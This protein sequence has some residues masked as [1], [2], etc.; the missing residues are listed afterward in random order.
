LH[1]ARWPVLL[2][3]LSLTSCTA[4]SPL[5]DV[6]LAADLFGR[7]QPH[8]RLAS[9]DGRG[10]E[11]AV[12]DL[13][14]VDA[15]P[16]TPCP[17]D[18]VLVTTTCLDRYEAP[19]L[20]GQL[21]LVMYTFLEAEA[22]CQARQKRLCFDDDWT[23][24]CATSA[25]LKYPYGSTHQAGTCN[26]DKLWKTYDQT[27]LNGWPTGVSSPSISSLA[28]LFAAAKATSTAGSVAADHVQALYQGTAAGSKPGCTN[29]FG[30]FDL[31]GNVEEWTRRRDGGTPSFHGNLKGRYWAEARTCQSGVTTHGDA[32][33]FYEIG[34]RCCR[35][36]VSGG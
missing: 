21:P 3:L 27:K 15:P 16:G 19:N 10:R 30:A 22:W 25:G 29:V 28:D 5:D 32:F 36:P 14:V 20:P 35:D 23:L 11:A 2:S 1:G 4:A 31:C 26:D 13:H 9:A 12:Q 33:R 18:M 7:D 34:F 17:S 24:A 6:H 8:D